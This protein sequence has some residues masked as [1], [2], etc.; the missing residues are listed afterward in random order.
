M[1]EKSESTARQFHIS[2]NL[3][4]FVA[5][6]KDA[7]GRSLNPIEILHSRRF[8]TVYLTIVWCFVLLINEALEGSIFYDLRIISE[9]IARMDPNE[10]ISNPLI[11][12]FSI[13]ISPF[14]HWN[15][16]HAIYVTAGIIFFLQSFEA[17]NNW[18]STTI[19]FI[20]TSA[21]TS[22]LMAS[23]YN[24]AFTINPNYE[25]FSYVMSRP[26]RGGSIGM[27]GALGA[28]AYHAKKPLFPLIL[29]FLFEIWN[30]NSFG[31][32]ASISIGHATSALIGLI[33]WRWWNEKRRRDSE[34]E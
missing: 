1:E 20:G 18:K 13:F 31:T 6:W 2:K 17:H 26:F 24:V 22:L 23:F 9:Q 10:L 28:L 34:S 27:F 12:L 21:L 3:L 15:T 32:H 8:T 30:F 14:A 29:V 4:G 25:L 33:S 5:P 7:S 16:V 19:I 11:F